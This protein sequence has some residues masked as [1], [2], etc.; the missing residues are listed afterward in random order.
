MMSSILSSTDWME[1]RAALRKFV[2]S[3]CSVRLAL[4][5]IEIPVALRRILA[6]PVLMIKPDIEPDRGI[7]SAILV[8]TQPGELVVEDLTVFLAEISILDAPVGD[9]STN[10]MNELAN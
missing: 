7:E 3:G 8:Q 5:G 4:L 6:D 2:L 1:T 9:G 10:T